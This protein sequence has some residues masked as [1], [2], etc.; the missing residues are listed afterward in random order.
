MKREHVSWKK[1][2]VELSI[3]ILALIISIP[4]YLVLINTFKSD[5]QIINEPL[6][7]PTFEF[8]FDNLIRA[9]DKMDVLRVYGNMLSIEVISVLGGVLLSSF[10]AYAVSRFEFK[11]FGVMY[12]VYIS[13]IL[14]P[15]QAA[16][17][18]IIQNMKHLGLNNTLLGI[19][20]VNMAVISPFAIFVY[21]GFMKSVPRELEEAAYIDGCSPARTYI[22]IIFP[23]IQP[24]TASLIILQFVHVWN[25]LMLPLVLVN[26]RD[27]PT[28]SVS[29]YKFFADRGLSDMGLLFGGISI[30]IAPVMLLFI[31]FQRFFIKGLSAGAV[32]G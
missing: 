32:K 1:V 28:I 9:W 27:I 29:L 8:G 22:Q 20:L 6:A 3:W 2:T 30:V 21:V 23:L 25:D 16:F 19:S 15:I 12:W 10:A 24:V 13:G 4:L 5:D 18:P 26:S 11:S 17:I 14:I 7:L 31:C